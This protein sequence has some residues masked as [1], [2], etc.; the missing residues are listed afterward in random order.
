MYIGID[1]GGSAV[2]VVGMEGERIL[3]THYENNSLRTASAIIKNVLDKS[4]ASL[5]AVEGIV[6]TGLGAERS[7]V[8]ALGRPV[9]RMVELSAIGRGATFLAGVERAVIAN[10]GTGTSFIKACDGEYTHLGGTGMGGGTLVG[11]GGCILGTG[12]VVEIDRLAKEGDLHQVD[13]TVGDL[14]SGA[15]S[16]LPPDLTAANLAKVTIDA[17]RNDWA[18][19]ILNLVTQVIG[20]MCVLSCAAAGLDTVVVT[21]ALASLPFAVDCYAFFQRMYGLRFILPEEGRFATAVG[22][23]LIGMGEQWS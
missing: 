8:E 15:G 20:T 14:C 9:K 19:G 13:L 7:D 21:G 18:A 10:T 1:L 4:G 16:T 3:F 17:D 22:A 5:E 6:A 12:D 2:K 23:V 11:L